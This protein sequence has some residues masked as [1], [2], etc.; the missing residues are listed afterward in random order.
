MATLRL[1]LL[2]AVLGLLATQ[3]LAQDAKPVSTHEQAAREL[4]R[5]V[6]VQRATEAGAEAMMGLIRNNP[7]LAPFEDVFRAWY[8]KVF[9]Q[10]DLEGE[11]A[12]IY[13]RHF[14][15]DEL[16]ALT[17]FYQTPVGRKA[18]D[19]LPAAMK[20][21]AELGMRRAKEHSAELEEM[22]KAARAERDRKKNAE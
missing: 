14:S 3:A 15:E 19:E 20:E 10:G 4:L 6:G 9:S 12:V 22:L 2:I 8:R 11:L 18:I 5:A 1:P 17:S 7:N 21:G 16:R 13:M